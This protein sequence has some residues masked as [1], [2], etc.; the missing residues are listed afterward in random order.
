M[1]LQLSWNLAKIARSA[2]VFV[3]FHV[4][5]NAGNSAARMNRVYAIGIEIFPESQ[6]LFCGDG[7]SWVS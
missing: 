1:F 3:T 2:G 5:E 4:R 6:A 7:G